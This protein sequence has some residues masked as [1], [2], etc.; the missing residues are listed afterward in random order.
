MEIHHRTYYKVIGSNHENYN[1]KYKL[2]L[3]VDI[4]PFDSKGKCKKG[5]LY[6]TT[7]EYLYEYLWFGEYVAEVKIPEDALVYK[8]D[9]RIYGGN[10]KYKANKIIITKFINMIDYFSVLSV[11]RKDIVMKILETDGH[12]LRFIRNPSIEMMTVSVK[13]DG[14]AIDNIKEYYIKQSYLQ[15]TKEIIQLDDDMFEKLCK[16]AVKQSGCAIKYITQ[17]SMKDTIKQDLYMIAVT[18]DGNAIQYILP[19]IMN[20]P[21]M[22]TICILAVK[23]NGLALYYIREQTL[24]ICLTA[25]RQNGLAL[26]YCRLRSKEIIDEAIKQNK[27]ARNYTH[28]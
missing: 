24:N 18:S 10:I 8:E 14:H 26:K 28:E 25:V 9:T 19:L 15:D 21:I 3:N 13:S 22:E 2:G 23:Q 17:I 16:L 20:S 12:M 5:G 6:F 11:K 27:E 7:E 1:F 4:N